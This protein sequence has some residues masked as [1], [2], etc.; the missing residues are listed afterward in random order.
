MSSAAGSSSRASTKPIPSDIRAAS[1]AL[2]YSLRDRTY[3]VVGGGALVLLGSNR[4]TEDVDFMVPQGKTK[5][6]GRSSGRR[7]L[8]SRSNPKKITH[9][10]RVHRPWR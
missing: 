9:T 6:F 3:G 7:Q 5:D 2:G 4:E 10:T 8:T 1:H